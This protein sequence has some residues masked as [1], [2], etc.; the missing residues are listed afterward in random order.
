[1]KKEIKLSKFFEWYLSDENNEGISITYWDRINEE[2]Y[3]QINILFRNC[4][5]VPKRLVE[6]DEDLCGDYIV[7]QEV[8]LVK[9]RKKF[10]YHLTTNTIWTSFDNGFVY[11]DNI[12][13]ARKLAEKEIAYN[14][15]KANE[16][17]GSY[18]ETEKFKIEMDLSQLIITEIN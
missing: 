6:G 2:M 13:E 18:S 8:I 4:K 11:A 14:C 3:Y 12:E 7:N 9:D 17:W 10:Q 1:M 15:K 5:V 16:L